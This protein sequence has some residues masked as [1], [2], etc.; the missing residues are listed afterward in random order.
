MK[1]T[2]DHYFQNSW[3]SC[4]LMFFKWCSQKSRNIY[5]NCKFI[6]KRFQHSCFPVN[7]ATF[8][9][10][11]FSHNTSEWLL[12][13][14]TGNHR[15][16]RSIPWNFIKKETMAQVFSRE[17]Y[18]I[19]KSTFFTKHLLANA[20]ENRKSYYKQFENECTIYNYFKKYNLI[21]CKYI[22]LYVLLRWK[23]LIG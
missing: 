9:K 19:F 4:S 5:R 6:R 1:F 17:F 10:T 22:C 15:K 21:L 3:C 7:I 23:N 12:M 13:K 14:F 18:E 2:S 16:E 8:L 11:P 20:S